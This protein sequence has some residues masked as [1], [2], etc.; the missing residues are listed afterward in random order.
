VP[1]LWGVTHTMVEGIVLT[2]RSSAQFVRRFWGGRLSKDFV[3]YR[4]LCIGLWRIDWQSVDL[5]R[6]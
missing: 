3:V 2:R 1:I 5:C 6:K 4:A